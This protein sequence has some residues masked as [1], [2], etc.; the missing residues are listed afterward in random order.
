[1]MLAFGVHEAGIRSLIRA[2]VAPVGLVEVGKQ[3]AWAEAG[4]PLWPGDHL[5]RSLADDR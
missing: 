5:L 1:M 3:L 2:A 4:T